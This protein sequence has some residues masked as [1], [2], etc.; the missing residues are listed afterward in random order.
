MAHYVY[1]R[2]DEQPQLE[3]TKVYTLNSDERS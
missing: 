1:K 3:S 2:P